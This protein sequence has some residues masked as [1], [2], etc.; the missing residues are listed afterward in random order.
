MQSFTT[1]AKGVQFK[2]GFAQGVVVC[3]IVTIVI[4]HIDIASN[5]FFLLAVG[6]SLGAGAILSIA[7]YLTYK[8]EW[9]EYN[10]ALRSQ[11]LAREQYAV[12]N[13]G[14]PEEVANMLIDQLEQEHASNQDINDLPFDRRTAI[15]NSLQRFMG[16]VAALSMIYLLIWPNWQSFWE[17]T[18]ALTLVKF[19][20][21][22]WKKT[23]TQMGK[24]AVQSIFPTLSSIPL[25]ALMLQLINRLLQ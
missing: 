21:E 7:H 9:M 1:H 8:E 22:C 2:S 15:M 19:A 6:T 11:A 18:V 14:V 10:A 20:A 16:S 3:Y 25:L 12:K 23:D 13:M 24:R 17:F 5:T 4:S